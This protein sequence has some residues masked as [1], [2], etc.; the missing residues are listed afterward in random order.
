MTGKSTSRR[1]NN[2]RLLPTLLGVVLVLVLALIRL[3]DPPPVAAIR[4]MGF[5]FYQRMMPRAGEDSPVRVLDIDDTSLAQLGQ[6]PWPRSMMATMTTR[7]GELGVAAIGFDVLFA[8]PD[9]LGAANDTAFADALRSSNSVLG[10]STSANAA[11]I[12]IDPK[13]GVAVS[14]SDPG[15]SLPPIRGAVVPLAVLAEAAPGLGGLSI[16]AEDS[17]GTVRRV[18]ML[19]TDGTRYYPGL[20]LETLRLALGVGT[21]VALGDTAGGNTLEAVRL[22]DLTVP[23]AANGDVILWDKPTQAAHVIPA[24]RLF[25]D[26]YQSLAGEFGGRIVLVGTSASGLLDLHATPL[27]ASKAGVLVHASMI[28][29]IVSNQFLGRA[30][31]LQGLEIL[32]FT[33]TGLLL[34]A[35]VLR[36][37][38]FAGLAVAVTC[39]SAA[40]IVSYVAFSTRGW[41]MDSTYPVAASLLVYGAMVYFQFS[42]AERDRLQVRRAFGYYVAPELLGVIERNAGKLELGGELRELTVMF[43]DM[44]GFTSFT[45]KHTPQDTLATLNTLFGALGKQIVDRLGTID[46][47]IGDAIM[48]FWNA[49]VDVAEHA[50]RACEAALA[51][52]QTLDALNR[53]KIFGEP[54]IAIGVGLSTGVAL[55]GNMGLATRFDYSTIGDTVNVASR[56]EGESKVVG[57]DIV[58][59]EGTRF[60]APDLAWLEAG[61]VQLKGKAQRLKVYVLVGDA[62]LAKTDAFLAL[63]AAHDALLLALRG[64]GDVA[65]SL[66]RCVELGTPIERRLAR[67]YELA[68]GRAEDF[69]VEAPL[70][71]LP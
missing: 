44:R 55:V 65:G 41:L 27:S 57:F 19:W 53:D 8:E 7:L 22:G 61:S 23:T 58:A 13:V 67:F 31:W 50:R 36:L 48:A 34:V 30:D 66:A 1:I 46:K 38:P 47:F 60:T 11:P 59:A 24:W 37:G 4:D 32:L 15:P 71:S 42:L 17:A 62:A 64:N 33:L 18:P 28:D 69:A 40:M 63:A 6:W 29:Q 43:A 52:R 10:F 2:R 16:N 51:M 35:V 5:D 54:G 45:E 56:V 25:A 68:P 49:P 20:S 70:T 9:R 3:A 12:V 14:G 26:D 21:I 39:I